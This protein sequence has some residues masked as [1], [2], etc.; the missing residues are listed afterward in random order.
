M[1]TPLCQG[2]LTWEVRVPIFAKKNR[3]HWAM[4]HHQGFEFNPAIHMI[5][6]V[7]NPLLGRCQDLLI[8]LARICLAVIIQI[9]SKSIVKMTAT[10]LTV[11]CF[12]VNIEF[13]ASFDS[14]MS[15]K[16]DPC[17]VAEVLGS[18]KKLI[19]SS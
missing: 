2:V 14:H 15:N 3:I 9:L 4:P 19:R 18:V 6:V 8:A 7:V 1:S 10:L 16:K 5:L 17:I 12:P 11:L 13:R